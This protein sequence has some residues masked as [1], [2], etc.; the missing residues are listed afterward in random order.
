MQVLCL[1]T[2]GEAVG[3]ARRIGVEGFQARLFLSSPNATA[4]GRGIVERVGS[5]RPALPEA[6]LIL[7]DA[8][9]WGTYEKTL[10]GYGR[11]TLGCSAQ[12]DQ[13]TRHPR[14]RWQLLE[15]LGAPSVFRDTL[16]S[17]ALTELSE[18]AGWGLRE[19]NGKYFSE[20]YYPV[21]ARD[22]EYLSSR[23]APNSVVIAEK[24]PQGPVFQIQAF[25]NGRRWVLP[26]LL[27]LWSGSPSRGIPFSYLGKFLRTPKLFHRTLE[28]LTPFMKKV[29]YRGSVI[30]ECFAA[31][32]EIVL[33]ELYFG[34]PGSYAALFLNGL[35]ENIADVFYEIALG[36]RNSIDVT[37]DYIA[38][39]PTIKAVGPIFYGAP[40][41]EGIP[42][43]GLVE[44][45]LRHVYLQSVCHSSRGFEWTP[46]SSLVFT[47]AA[48]GRD[49][50]EATRRISDTLSVLSVLR[51]VTNTNLVGCEENLKALKSMNW[52]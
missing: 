31:K 50:K 8:P 52:L 48:R 35:K 1:S 18:P 32:E 38:A 43:N 37:N 14:N 45:N 33:R 42:I 29:S 36:S 2:S 22:L 41:D 40:E 34:F 17:H 19:V 24:I 9:G 25:W 20:T 13:L 27:V 47:T 51:T 46:G 30:L 16:E 39:V 21:S 11:P 10:R 49:V 15:T 28:A 3:V 7:C 44:E 5:W 6:D 23:M 12:T 4:V 26:A